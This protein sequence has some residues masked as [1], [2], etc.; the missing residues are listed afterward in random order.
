MNK[1]VT[2]PSNQLKLAHTSSSYYAFNCGESNGFVLIAADDNFSNE[3][4][5]YADQGTFDTT[6]IPA[7]MRWWLSEYD[8]MLEAM[9]E[10]EN[11]TSA[12][13][14][15]VKAIQT[16]RA[17]IKP[18]LKSKWN[19]DSPYNDKCPLYNGSRC[20]TGCLATAIAQ[21]I[22]YNQYPSQGVGIHSYEWFVGQ[23]S[24]GT[25]S[26]DFSQ[27]TYDYETMSDTYNKNS[28]QASRAAVAQLM[29]DVGVAS[30]MSYGTDAS[31]AIS[32]DGAKGLIRNFNY[33][34]SAI[35]LLRDFYS[36]EEWIDMLYTSLAEN[37]PL[38]YA[39]ANAGA[40]HAFVCDGYC[41]GYFHI[42]WGWGGYYDGYFLIG[43]LDP[44][45]QGIGGSD[46][47]YNQNQ[48]AIFNIKPAQADSKYVTLMYN[49]ADFD[50]AQKTQTTSSRNVK[51]SGAFYNFSLTAQD[52]TVGIKVVNSNGDVTWIEDPYSDIIESYRGVAEIYIHLSNFPTAAGTYTVYPAYKDEN[53]EWQEMRTVNTSNKK[54]LTATVSGTSI[55]F[56]N[57]VSGELEFSNWATTGIYA[58]EEFSVQV[59][60]ANNTG[61]TFTDNI[62]FVL[63]EY[64]TT[65][66]VSY[67]D[68]VSVN[69]ANGSSYTATFTLTAPATP[70]YYNFVVV[71]S[72]WY[73]L[74]NISTLKVADNENELS[75]T[76]N[77]L[78]IENATNV[79]LDNIN[80]SAEISCERGSYNGYIAFAVYPETG[81]YNIDLVYQ[82]FR[83]ET[84]QT[85]TISNTDQ[86][87]KLETGKDYF[88]ALFYYDLTNE[89]WIQLGSNDQVAFFTTANPNGINEIT[90]EDTPTETSVYNLS[91][92]RLLHFEAGEALDTSSLEPGIYIVKSGNK[93]K[94]ILIN[95]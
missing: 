67:S 28:S 47:G 5:G 12:T 29:N 54:Y 35:L 50:I 76:L 88:I 87:T 90:N 7:N 64:G 91:G 43:A 2:P 92:I 68:E 38:Y 52:I 20:Y 73:N 48:E 86:F 93:S 72:E 77:S 42:N 49:Y 37:R 46:S 40:G 63:L 65:S 10:A 6:T 1:S 39:G 41:D 45:G 24:Q 27:H 80:I 16:E 85:Q 83:I 59:D 82:S 62:R 13:R 81:G 89:N 69:I 31:G 55:T 9:Q 95:N 78:S 66:D 30:N 57:P 75:L 19:Q 18:L 84:G 26:T 36:E 74:C 51:F 58:G 71:N 33:D 70:G 22:Y 61:A 79:S 4:L 17:E 53:N 11:N 3:I 32:L 56:A 14:I 34:K 25:L 21:I 8:R 60:I 94:R 15:Q 23:N 44:E